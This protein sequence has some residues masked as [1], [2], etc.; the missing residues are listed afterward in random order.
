MSTNL[1]NI[2]TIKLKKIF[3]KKGSVLHCLKNNEKSFVQFGERQKTDE[4]LHTKT[5]RSSVER[6][7]LCTS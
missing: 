1:K 7:K 3:S 2:R 4:S 6:I 5:S